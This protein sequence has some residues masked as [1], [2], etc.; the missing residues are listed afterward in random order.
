MRT[1]ILILMKTILAYLDS[2]ARLRGWARP[3]AFAASLVV[4]CP[5]ILLSA[6][7]ALRPNERTFLEKAIESSRQQLRLADVGAA[8][9]TSSD[10]R[11]HALQLNADYRD[12]RDALEALINRKGGL[13]GAPVG[14]TSETYQKLSARAGEEFDREFVRIAA[15][16]SDSVMT[17]FEQAANNAKDGEVREF[18]S[19]QL[20]LLRSHQNRS[21][22]L[23]KAF[24]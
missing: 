24:E 9:A 3:V 23:R 12:L 19:A 17:L 18:A 16:L 10:L 14:G 15:N 5:A 6:T 4:F 2:S 13:A 7:D 1:L 21:V 22:E 8:Q 20:P 11:S